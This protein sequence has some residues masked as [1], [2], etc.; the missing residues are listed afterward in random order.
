MYVANNVDRAS[1]QRRRL[2]EFTRE[3]VQDLN[4][5]LQFTD[6]H[7][8]LKAPSTPFVELVVLERENRNQNVKHENVRQ[9]HKTENH[10]ELCVIP[11]NHCLGWGERV[12]ELP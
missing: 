4:L 12:V 8:P 7:R 3:A 5:R 11:V 2:V 9:K 10:D 6:E 1:E